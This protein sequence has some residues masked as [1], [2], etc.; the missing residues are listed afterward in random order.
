[1]QVISCRA[2]AAAS[3]SSL[4]KPLSGLE[5]ASCWKAIH[6]LQS[7]P[8]STLF[9]PQKHPEGLLDHFQMI[10]RKESC[11][12]LCFWDHIGRRKGARNPEK[13]LVAYTHPKQPWVSTATPQCQLPKDTLPSAQRTGTQLGLSIL[14]HVWSHWKPFSSCPVDTRHLFFICAHLHLDF[15]HCL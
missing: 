15:R 8:L 11:A 14:H 3:S 13:S 5:P 10:F 12:E 7:L 1:M 9:S 4:S 6:L 2:T